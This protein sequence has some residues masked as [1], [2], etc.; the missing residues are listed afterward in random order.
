MPLKFMP[1]WRNGRR[2][3]LKILRWRHR[4]GSSPTTGTNEQ[5]QP[6]RL[7]FSFRHREVFPPSPSLVLA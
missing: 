5:E 2:T 1:V 7:F 4:V 3:G 6:E